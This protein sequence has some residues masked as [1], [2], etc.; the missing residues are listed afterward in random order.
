[1]RMRG[2]E[3]EGGKR[4]RERER[5]RRARVLLT[6]SRGGGPSG[7]FPQEREGN[8][9]TAP[10]GEGR[11]TYL[12]QGIAGNTPGSED[13]NQKRLDTGALPTP[14]HFN[15]STSHVTRVVWCGARHVESFFQFNTFDDVGYC[16]V[17]Y[18]Q[19]HPSPMKTLRW[20]TF[21]I[22]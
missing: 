12:Q 5:E 18:T 6:A 4:E 16:C 3:R 1:M 10:P 8:T 17:V 13:G 9:G 22:H 2:S 14:P 15:T 7:P 21:L 19:C 20:I 11:G